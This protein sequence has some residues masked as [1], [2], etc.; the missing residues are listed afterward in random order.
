M[1]EELKQK[2]RVTVSFSRKYSIAAYETLDLHV[3]LAEDIREQETSSQAFERVNKEVQAFFEKLCGKIEGERKSKG[4]R[5][6]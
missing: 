6:P 1:G 5:K 4:G 3:G 2:G